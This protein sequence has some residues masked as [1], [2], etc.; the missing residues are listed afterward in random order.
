LN[1]AT[2]VVRVVVCVVTR[3]QL[4]RVLCCYL[5]FMICS[6]LKRERECACLCVRVRACVCVLVN[7]RPTINRSVC[8]GVRRPYGTCDQF[9]FL[10]KILV[11]FAWMLSMLVPYRLGTFETC[12]GVYLFTLYDVHGVSYCTV[13]MSIV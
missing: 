10:L 2:L 4:I 13:S 6:A 11:P 1:C 3:G 12:I 7:L 9:C 5:V 8:P